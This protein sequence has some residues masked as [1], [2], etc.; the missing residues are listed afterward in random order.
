RI[1]WGALVTSWFWLVGA[2][3]LSL[4]PPLVKNAFG[5][6]EDVV[7]MC[8]AI[9]SVSIA[10][11]S[12]LAAW[13]A[14]GRIILLPTLIGAV[15]LG[16]FAIDLGWSTW[17]LMPA[18]EG[19]GIAA[20][21][22]TGRGLHMAVDL[23]GLAIAG[24]LFMVPTFSAA[25]AWAGADRRARLWWVKPFLKLTRALPLD[26]MKPMGVRT[27]IEAVRASDAL[28]IFPEGR[29][30]VTGSL[31]KVYDGAAMIADKSDAEVV[32]VRIEGLEQT[33]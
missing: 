16:L 3:A 1:W 30:T 14:A 15:L 13:L 26:P 5:G 9:F 29:I 11:G 2:V 28:I 24:G 23:A 7:T 12:V 6:S 32:P 21:F 10:I 27:L 31:M 17:N 22:G 19:Q 8:L 20:V 25:Q 18:A 4:L 33:P